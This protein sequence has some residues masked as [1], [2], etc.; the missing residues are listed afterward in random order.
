MVGR[1]HAYEGYS[2]QKLTFP[3]RVMKALGVQI[4]LVT[5]ASGGLNRA[6]RVGDVMI[7]KDHISL[8]GEHSHP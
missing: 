1:L 5:N 2:S 3:V 4:L 7:I 8:P 6:F